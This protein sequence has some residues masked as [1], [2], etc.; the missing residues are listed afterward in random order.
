MK[1]LLSGRR[2]IDRRTWLSAA[3][4]GFWSLSAKAADDPSP[5]LEAIEAR[6]REVGLANFRT[7]KTEHYLVTGNA[8][9]E[10]RKK[11]SEICE[12]VYRDY[13]DY[14]QKLDFPAKPPA[15]PLVVVALADPDSFAAFLGADQAQAV[16]G[17]YDLD[18]NWLIVFDNR[19]RAQANSLAAKANTLSLVHEATH[20]LT[21]NTGLLNRQGD[22]PA[23]ISE[24]L[25]MYVEVRGTTSRST[26]GQKNVLRLNGIS[27]GKRKGIPWIPV[28]KLLEDDAPLLGNEGPDV[29][30]M[31]YAESWVLVYTLLKDPEWRPRF[32]A[33]LEAI[34]PRTAKDHRLDDARKTLGDLERLDRLVRKNAHY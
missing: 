2:R 5:D 23:C 22:I 12:G 11:A 9:D 34:R 33:Y 6:A 17:I 19:Q 16:G 7:R 10:F 3:I 26:P 29:Q 1:D 13:M 32:R 27:D 24:G 21:F 14:F 31:A 18:T 25:A 15:H 20:Q 30:Q 4:A 8:T 28:A